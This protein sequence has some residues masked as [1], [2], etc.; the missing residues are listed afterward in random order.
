MLTSVFAELLHKVDPN[1]QVSFADVNYNVN[2]HQ[3]TC[4]IYELGK[5]ME[6]TDS[7]KR[8]LDG[9]SLKLAERQKEYLA[10]VPAKWVP[11]YSQYN[12]QLVVITPGYRDVL[13]KICL[14]RPQYKERIQKIFNYPNGFQY[15]WDNQAAPRRALRQGVEIKTQKTAE[16]LN[17]TGYFI[18][19]DQI[20]EIVS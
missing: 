16:E 2:Q 15:D 13:R 9:D 18:D 17:K 5:W 7:E 6:V 8:L 1:L 14:L 11:E 10:Y 3:G 19:K 20:H 4:P 12:P